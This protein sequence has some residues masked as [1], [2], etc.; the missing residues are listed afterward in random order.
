[1]KVL[2]TIPRDFATENLKKILRSMSSKNKKGQELIFPAGMIESFCRLGRYP[3]Y[4][5][6]HNLKGQHYMRARIEEFTLEYIVIT[7]S[8]SANYKEACVCQI[9]ENGKTIYTRQN[10]PVGTILV[11]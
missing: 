3:C 6:A 1:M 11:L 4:R 2:E 10:S 5:F 8:K 7:D 9:S